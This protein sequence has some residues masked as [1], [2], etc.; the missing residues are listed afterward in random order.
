MDD[1]IGVASLRPYD[2]S[3]GYDLISLGLVILVVLLVGVWCTHF[4]RQP[5][6]GI[7]EYDR[8]C[9]TADP[10]T[11][12]GQLRLARWVETNLKPAAGDHIP[13]EFKAHLKEALVLERKEIAAFRLAA[14]IGDVNAWAALKELDAMSAPPVLGYAREWYRLRA[15]WLDA[16]DRAGFSAGA[17]FELSQVLDEI[18]LKNEAGLERAKIRAARPNFPGLK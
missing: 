13:L 9:N 2:E 4:F 7:E 11:A 12:A 1:R 6:P 14:E 3:P 18:G 17:H 10:G 15:S 8:V 5:P 16:R